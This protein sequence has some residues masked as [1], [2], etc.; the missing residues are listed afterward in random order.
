MACR[1]DFALV[2]AVAHVVPD[3]RRFFAE[4]FA[5]LRPGE[6]LLFAEPRGHVGTEEFQASLDAAFGA[7]F[8]AGAIFQAGSA[9]DI[10]R[11]LSAL[12]KKP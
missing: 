7:G 9:P 12:L 4:L 2:F 1:T 8:R 11:T 6:R 3:Q 5:T 10:P